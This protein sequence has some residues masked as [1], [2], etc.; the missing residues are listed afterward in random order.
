MYINKVNTKNKIIQGK[1]G[2]KFL[3]PVRIEIQPDR[4]NILSLW[5][6]IKII[7]QPQVGIRDINNCIT[8]IYYLSG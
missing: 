2:R 3:E 4:I 7:M 5:Q 8:N 1:K 6:L